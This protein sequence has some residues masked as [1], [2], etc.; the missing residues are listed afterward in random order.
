MVGW[1]PTGVTR[2]SAGGLSQS[3]NISENFKC[4]YVQVHNEPRLM[5]RLGA[6]RP[7]GG[8]DSQTYPVQANL[9]GTGRQLHGI[10]YSVNNVQLRLNIEYTFFYFIII[11][12]CVLEAF[13]L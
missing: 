12:S 6:E 1:G 11:F 9:G 2:N 3:S 7:R 13:Y 5:L 8:P 10:V 4:T